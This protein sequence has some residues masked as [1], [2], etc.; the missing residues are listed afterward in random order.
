M[1]IHQD[2]WNFYS[3]IKFYS[4]LYYFYSTKSHYAKQR[5][6]HEFR[7]KYLMIGRFSI[8][9]EKMVSEPCFLYFFLLA[10]GNNYQRML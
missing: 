1:C 9:F 2:Q 5:Q 3:R 7:A 10:N 4:I 8:D 6:S